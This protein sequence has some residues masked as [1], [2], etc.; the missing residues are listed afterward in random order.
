MKKILLAGEFRH[1][2]PVL[3]TLAGHRLIYC[4]HF[5]SLKSEWSAG[6]VKATALSLK[7]LTPNVFDL[8]TEGQQRLPDVKWIL[9]LQEAAMDLTTY[10]T[11]R[12][13]FFQGQIAPDWAPRL[14]RW[15]QGSS[16]EHRKAPRRTCRGGVRLGDSDYSRK[17][18]GAKAYGQIEDLS[19]HGIGLI[20]EEPLVFPSSEF[21]EVAFRDIQG[22]SRKFHAQIR[23][24]RQESD[25]RVR[26]GLQFLAAA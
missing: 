14:S 22:Q 24:I 12:Q 7:E 26:V 10:N 8:L 16:L 15:L 5:E 11:N 21:V 25:G 9:F 17:T 4:R 18:T 20:F 1:L 2:S 6:D 23:W 3:G 13:M 19:T